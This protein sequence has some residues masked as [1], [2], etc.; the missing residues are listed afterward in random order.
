MML[1]HRAYDG[2]WCLYIDHWV[3]IC[4]CLSQSDSRFLF[5]CLC[6]S[7][8]FHNPTN[9]LSFASLAIPYWVHVYGMMLLHRAY[10][11]GRRLYIDHWVLICL[12]V[13]QSDSRFLF[14]C[15]CVSIFFDKPTNWLSCASLATPHWVHVYVVMRLHRAYDG[16]WCLYIYHWVSICLCLSQSDSRFAY[17]PLPIHFL[18]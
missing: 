4:L 10:D 12:C 15:L 5:T 8:F 9:W 18:W 11:G 16:G 2:G 7:I 3:S 13:S 1:L 14:T 17:M 6:L